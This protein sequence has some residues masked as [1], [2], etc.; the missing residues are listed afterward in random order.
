[1]IFP[2]VQLLTSKVPEKLSLLIQLLK[3]R[4][5]DFE[6]FARNTK[7][8]N[9]QVTILGLAQDANQS[10]VELIAQVQTLGRMDIVNAAFTRHIKQSPSG[11]EGIF[12]ACESCLQSLLSAY[13]SIVNEHSLSE[14]LQRLVRLQLKR[15]ESGY[16]TFKLLHT[17]SLD[18]G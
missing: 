9:L 13:Q 5:R 14:H 16:V 11:N 8:K 6:L 18:R 3:N 10:A 2:P 17:H 7:D 12:N 15:V 1:M 4:K